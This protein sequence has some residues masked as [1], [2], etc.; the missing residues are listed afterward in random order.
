MGAVGGDLVSSLGSAAIVSVQLADRGYLGNGPAHLA[1]VADLP[2][3]VRRVQ[4]LRPAVSAV[5]LLM[6][7]AIVLVALLTSWVCAT[8]WTAGWSAVVYRWFPSVDSPAAA[9]SRR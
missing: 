3:A 9:R 5:G 8:L 2:E 6:A 1:V 4:Q 7:G